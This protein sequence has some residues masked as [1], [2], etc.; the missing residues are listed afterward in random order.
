M[1]RRACIH[2]RVGGGHAPGGTAECARHATHLGAPPRLAKEQATGLGHDG[3]NVGEG[4]ALVKALPTITLQQ[5]AAVF[6]SGGRGLLR[7]KLGCYVCAEASGCMPHRR[8]Q[9]V[10]KSAPTGQVG[11]HRQW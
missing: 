3:H 4:T 2:V 5:D 6:G 11:V 10:H 9:R 8:A 7:S 1:D